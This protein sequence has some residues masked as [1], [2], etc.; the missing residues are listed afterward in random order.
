MKVILLEK[1]SN[2]K[3]KKIILTTISAGFI[4][5]SLAPFLLF[6]NSGD[7]NNINLEDDRFPQC[8]YRTYEINSNLGEDRIF[9][10]KNYDVSIYPE[11]NNLKCLGKTFS[12]TNSSDGIILYNIS[13]SSLINYLT[14]FHLLIFLLLSIY[15]KIKPYQFLFSAIFY[16][17]LFLNYLI[18]IKSLI[19]I[20]LY[21]I[22]H[23]LTL[24]NLLKVDN[25]NKTLKS[26]SKFE[27]ISSIN[28]LRAI[29][30]ISVFGYH[31]NKTLL[32]GGYLGVDVFIFISGFLISN[33][34]IS[35]INL[36][37]FTLKDFYQR[38]IKRLFPALFF[39]VFIT[40]IFSN[41]IFD[42]NQYN[43]LIKSS[44]ASI[45]FFSNYYFKNINF[46]TNESMELMPLLHTWSL[47]LEEQFYLLFPIFILLILKLKKSYIF[48]SGILLLSIYLNVLFPNNTDV[49]YLLP[50]RI[51]EFMFGFFTMLIFSKNIRLKSYNSIFGYILLIISFLFFSE[52]YILSVIP[53]ILIGFSFFLIVLA[54]NQ[55]S[56]KDRFYL[57]GASSYSFYL[58]HQPIIS[59]YRRL[60]DSSLLNIKETVVLFVIILL[61]AIVSY[62][63]IERYFLDKDSLKINKRLASLFLFIIIYL[64]IQFFTSTKNLDSNEN[65]SFY[66]SLIPQKSNTSIHLCETDSTYFD[67]FK[68][69]NDICELNNL[70]NKKQI[71]IIGDSHAINV[72]R[73]IG[74]NLDS[75]YE[76]IN[77]VG[78]SGKCLLFSKAFYENIKCE[79]SFYTS[80]IDLI[81]ENSLII[82]SS[83]L[84]YWLEESRFNLLEGTTE[85]TSNVPIEIIFKNRLSEISS[86]SETTILIYPIPTLNEDIRSILPDPINEKR[87]NIYTRIENWQSISEQSKVL[88]NGIESPNVYRIFPEKVL[89]NESIESSGTLSCLIVQDSEFL[90]Y[91]DNHLSKYGNNII[92]K[93]VFK[94]LEAK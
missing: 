20:L 46:Y 44:L 34:I 85:S 51:W 15:K 63:N 50:Y 8:V 82:V 9:F 94:L 47:S 49:F 38:R 64:I 39:T 19:L 67:S 48:L 6:I 58:L 40:V 62:F 33:V 74:N 23:I 59:T 17:I 42:E 7:I 84:P 36:K 90:Y 2:L 21:L 24:L 78:G 56:K 83:R 32:P 75:E 52:N 11:I 79:E 41:F 73:S 66:N 37:T 18:D 54:D 72:A 91:D 14:N 71:I 45:F 65:I 53:K 12:I 5:L 4:I 86:L 80:F 25:F 93:E 92:L 16:L 30:V 68:N 29:S 77:I 70:D 89:C 13:S 1:Y 31:V 88:L 27:Y 81:D 55:T 3:I 28:S 10:V 69:I 22:I 87:N 26:V 57:I 61:L 76:I 43:L 35:K 60:S